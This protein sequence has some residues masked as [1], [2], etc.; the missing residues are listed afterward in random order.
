MEM[1][2]KEF[3]SL[4]ALADFVR[5]RMAFLVTSRP[6]AV[7][8]S[9]SETKLNI[10]IKEWSAEEAANVNTVKGKYVQAIVTVGFLGGKGMGKRERGRERQR[11]EGMRREEEKTVI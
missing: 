7:N 2:N 9:D 3:S 4:Q 11:G 5:E 10:L 8:I 6:T 1:Y